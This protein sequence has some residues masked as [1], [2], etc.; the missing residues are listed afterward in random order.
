MLVAAINDMRGVSKGNCQVQAPSKHLACND[1]FTRGIYLEC[2]GTTVYP[3]AVTFLP[4]DDPL[5]AKFKRAFHRSAR[6]QELADAPSPR[7]VTD[8][9]V[10]LAMEVAHLSPY[11]TSSDR[12]PSKE[13]G[14]K[15]KSVFV[16][17]LD[18]WC[19][20]M[21]NFRDTDHMLLNRMR[22][23]IGLW[24]GSENCKM[25]PPKMKFEISLGRF[26]R[27][28]AQTSINRDGK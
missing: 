8:E 2:Y 22:L 17:W 10:R 6:L 12:H 1:C 20:W 26:R 21:M 15:A 25:T 18:Y 28:N 3:S 19:P 5:R 27:Y 24:A 14:F 23:I 16:K 7:P 13:Y 4:P 11:K 9:Y